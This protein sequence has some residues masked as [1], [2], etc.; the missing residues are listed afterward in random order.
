MIFKQP[1]NHVDVPSNNNFSFLSSQADVI[2]L[3]AAISACAAAMR[4]EAVLA[5]L[6]GDGNEATYHAA[7]A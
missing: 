2:S 5:L 1:F 3:T 4:W 7:V 6:R